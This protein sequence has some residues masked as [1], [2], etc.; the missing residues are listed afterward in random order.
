M[1]AKSFW[2]QWE[3]FEGYADGAF[4]MNSADDAWEAD[5]IDVG[6]QPTEEAPAVDDTQPLTTEERLRRAALALGR[7]WLD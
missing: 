7:V 3:L 6:E 2:L 1:D 5:F 4:E